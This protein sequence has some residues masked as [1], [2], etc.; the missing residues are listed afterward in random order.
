MF[1]KVPNGFQVLD[2]EN[3]LGGTPLGEWADLLSTGME[4]CVTP[5]KLQE[6]V[7]MSCLMD[8]IPFS[9]NAGVIRLPVC[10]A[11]CSVSGSIVWKFLYTL[12]GINCA[13]FHSLLWVSNSK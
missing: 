4:G 11:G 9:C 6:P 8:D 13:L 7:A 1:N 10:K 5:E 12:E 2:G 3:L